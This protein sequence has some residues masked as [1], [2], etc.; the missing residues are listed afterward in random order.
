M[1]PRGGEGGQDFFLIH[2]RLLGEVQFFFR[3]FGCTTS[4]LLSL[5]I[6]K[7]DNIW[8]HCQKMPQSIKIVININPDVFTQ[9]IHTKAFSKCHFDKFKWT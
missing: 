5:S 1:S 4:V 9:K 3:C 8:Q 2:F 6:E 7:F